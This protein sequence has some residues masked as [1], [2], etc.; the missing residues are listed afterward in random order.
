MNEYV[1]VKGLRPY[2]DGGGDD[3]YAYVPI[4]LIV[5]EIDRRGGFKEDSK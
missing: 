5:K 2:M 1:D 4:E 3:P